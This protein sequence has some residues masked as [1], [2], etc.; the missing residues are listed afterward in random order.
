MYYGNILCY[1]R[2]TEYGGRIQWKVALLVADPME[3]GKD[4]TTAMGN[5]ELERLENVSIV[6][7]NFMSKPA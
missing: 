7:K 2:A 4:V 6:A 3:I 1:N 5:L